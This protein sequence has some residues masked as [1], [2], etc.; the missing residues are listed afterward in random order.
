MNSST[1]NFSKNSNGDSQ[2]S[3]FKKKKK[4]KLYIKNKFFFSKR[5]KTIYKVRIKLHFVHLPINGI[6]LN[7]IKC[8]YRG[9]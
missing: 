1:S 2:N 5:T 3:F 9:I 6:P 7:N 8:T 4:W